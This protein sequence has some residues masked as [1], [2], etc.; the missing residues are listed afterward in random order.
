MVTWVSSRTVF[1]LCPCWL[2]FTFQL[3]MQ[4]FNN[5]DLEKS[6]LTQGIFSWSLLSHHESNGISLPFCSKVKWI[7][8]NANVTEIHFFSYLFP[9]SVSPSAQQWEP[10]F[11]RA[12]PIGLQNM[13]SSRQCRIFCDYIVSKQHQINKVKMIGC[14]Q[15][16]AWSITCLN[17]VVLHHS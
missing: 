5:E 13:M 2:P 14:N 9:S 11:F 3:I 12:F 15:L 10:P 7:M 17:H 6:T 4:P 16:N 8:S 1:L